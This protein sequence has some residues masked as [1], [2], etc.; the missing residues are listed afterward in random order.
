VSALA[1]QL[2]RQINGGNG[3]I[4]DALSALRDQLGTVTAAAKAAGI[5]RRTFQRH[6]TGKIRSA[7]PGTAE[8]VRLAA[9]GVS[10][11][12]SY[13]GRERNLSFGG[14]SHLKLKPGTPAAIAA[15]HDRGDR[16]GMAKAFIDG[17]E[18]DWYHD[19]LDATYEGDDSSGDYGATFG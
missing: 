17:I 2:A 9:K 18:D 15:A 12:W 6:M 8:R 1:D 16:E 14:G 19:A 5:D 7:K 10:V 4:R 3:S 11:K 13:D